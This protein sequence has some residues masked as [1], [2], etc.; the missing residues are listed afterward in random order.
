MN[1]ANEY[2]MNTM[3]GQKFIAIHLRIGSD[4][5]SILIA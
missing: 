1:E 5:V 3:N 2:L 4:W